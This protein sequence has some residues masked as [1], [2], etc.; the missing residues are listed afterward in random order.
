MSKKMKWML[1]FKLAPEMAT[2]FL[3][4]MVEIDGAPVYSWT[5]DAKQALQFSLNHA[6]ELL[7]MVEA[8]AGH[9]GHGRISLIAA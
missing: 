3:K 4:G 6:T 1:A 2:M 9:G 7:P 5:R 8:T